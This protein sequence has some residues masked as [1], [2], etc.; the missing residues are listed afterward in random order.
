LDSANM[1]MDSNEFAPPGSFANRTVIVTGGAGSIG[2]PLCLAFAAAGAN[3]VVNDLGGDISGSGS[4][5]SPASDVVAEIKRNGGSAVVDTHSVTDAEAIIAN[6][7]QAFGRIDIIVNNAGITRYGM[8]E[9]QT[10]E[11][12][13]AVFEVN[14]AGPMALLHHAWPHFQAQNY[15]RVVNFSSD[16]LFGMTNSLPYVVSRGAMFGATRT[17][18]LEGAPHNIIVNAVNPTSYS[19]MMEPMFKDLPPEHLAATKNS[20]PGEA[21]VPPILALTH[22]SCAVTGQVFS[23]GS[24]GISRI[25]LGTTSEVSNCR[26]M[27]EVQKRLPELMELGREYA[28]P[29][30][31]IEFADFRKKTRS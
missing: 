13:K 16:S 3:V 22:E 28:E 20:Y 26:T 15:G 6:A 19:R 29:M 31:I 24:Y 4:S 21:N 8:L 27:S 17:L 25:M 1:S 12:F 5:A 7:L 14:A 2:R 11:A 30:N 23:C 9:A 18:A 10:P